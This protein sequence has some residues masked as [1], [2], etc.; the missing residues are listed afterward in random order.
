VRLCQLLSFP[1]TSPSTSA[2]F[3]ST[4]Q[5]IKVLS[6]FTTPQRFLPD[7]QSIVWVSLFFVTIAWTVL[8]LLLILWAGVSFLHDNFIA[9]WPLKLLR[10]M[11]LLS[12]SILFQPLF[13]ML[14]SPFRCQDPGYMSWTLSGWNCKGAGIISLQAVGCL[15][16]FLLLGF[17]AIFSVSFYE[18]NQLSKQV[19]SKAHGR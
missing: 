6:A 16:A 10:G 1:L 4:I 17:A 3:K 15:L 9:L 2:N 13:G 12:V 7:V 18:S 5:P 14:L 19:I 11:G 8:L